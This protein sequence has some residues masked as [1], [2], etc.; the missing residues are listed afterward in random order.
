MSLRRIFS[1]LMKYSLLPLLSSLLEITTSSNSIGKIWFVL[2]KWSSTSQKLTLFLFS[3][4]IKITSCMLCPRSCFAL[5]SP[6]THLMASATL[7][8]PEP[9]GPTIA[10]ILYSNGIVVLSANDLKP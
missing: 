2:S 5:L 6:K 9:L 10:V 1:L 7:L 4:P 3:V 8:L